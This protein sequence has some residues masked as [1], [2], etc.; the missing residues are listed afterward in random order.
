MQFLE[1]GGVSPREVYFRPLDLKDAFQQGLSICGQSL[2]YLRLGS[3]T[4]FRFHLLCPLFS[5]TTC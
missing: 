2:N 5:D 1:N 4:V 3:N